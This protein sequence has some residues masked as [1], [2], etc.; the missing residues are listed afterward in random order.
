MTTFLARTATVAALTS[1]ILPVITGAVAAP[2]ATVPTA[3]T[4]AV[5]G[6]LAASAFWVQQGPSDCLPMSVRTVVATVTGRVVTPKAIDRTAARVTGYDKDGSTFETAGNLF[7]SYGVAAVYQPGATMDMLRAALDVGHPVV[8]D[9]DANPIWGEWG[10]RGTGDGPAWHAL[11][12]A[13]IDDARHAVTLV[14]SGW[15]GGMA[16]T[17]PAVAFLRAWD[18]SG[19]AAIFVE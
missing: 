16:E 15:D 9:I 3:P 10:M 17:I 19:H 12:V 8:V 14:D 6:T 11:T 2:G 13:Q 1:A 7:A 4:F 18:A 5:H